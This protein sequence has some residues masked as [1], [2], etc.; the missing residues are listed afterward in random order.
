[1]LLLLSTETELTVLAS[2]RSELVH[3]TLT[4]LIREV[5][6][7]DVVG[8]HVNLLVGVV[9]AVVNLLHA[10]TLLDEESVTVDWGL[11]GTLGS[12]LVHVTDLQ[13]VLK[14]VK[15]DLDDL[16]VGAGEEIAKWA[17][18]TVLNK[19]AELVGLL[20]TTGSGVGDGPACLLSGLEVAVGKEMDKR[21]HE[22]GINN[23]L[24]LGRV[25]SSDV[26]DGPASLLANSILGGAQKREKSS[27]SARVDDDLG[28]DVVASNDVAD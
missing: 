25:A 9:L 14:T 13:D 17:D 24:D 23:R 18:S 2:L 5:L 20:E 4:L 3:V 11:V 16:V 12:L 28:L 6:L 7:D 15:S 21:V 27:E 8:L 22:A 10:T 1:M 19:V 26:G